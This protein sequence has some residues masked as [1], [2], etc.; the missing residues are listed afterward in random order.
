MDFAFTAMLTL[1][2]VVTRAFFLSCSHDCCKFL[3]LQHMLAKIEH[4]ARDINRAVKKKGQNESKQRQ[5]WK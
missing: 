4:D 2:G 5:N 1:R 3:L